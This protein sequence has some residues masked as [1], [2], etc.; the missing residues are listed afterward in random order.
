LA[1]AIIGA[2]PGLAGGL[3]AGVLASLSTALLTRYFKQQEVN[4]LLPFGAYCAL[5]GAATLVFGR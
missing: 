5:I 2:A 1:T 4:V 3:I